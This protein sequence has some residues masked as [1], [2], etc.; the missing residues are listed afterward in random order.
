MARAPLFDLDVSVVTPLFGGGA[1]A[2]VADPLAP[3]RAAS[4]RGHLRFWW[5]ACKSAGFATAD[6]LFDQEEAIWGS[7]A[8]PSPVA[9]IVSLLSS[10]TK[11]ESREYQRRAD[12]RFPAY[13]LFPTK[14]LLARRWKTCDSSCA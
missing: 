13:A 1:T 6:A 4:V 2:G 10:G 3:V 9:V 12:G 5:R 8:Y 7:T 11:V 14:T